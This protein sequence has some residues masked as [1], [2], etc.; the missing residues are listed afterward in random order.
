[1][2]IEG[3]FVQARQDII[4]SWEL[5]RENWRAFVSTEIFSIIAFICI[6]VGLE[7]ILIAIEK[8]FVLDSVP[9]IKISMTFISVFIG[10]LVL[11]I[12]LACQYGLAYDIISSGDMFAEFKGAF[13]YFKRYWWRYALLTFLTQWLQGVFQPPIL[14]LRLFGISLDKFQTGI[15]SPIIGLLI[16]SL[17][18]Y[19]F[20]FVLF[21]NTLPSITFQKSL[22][23]SFIENIKIIRRIPQR[24]VM[25][26][27][28]VFFIFIVPEYLINI[29]TII[30]FNSIVNTYWKFVP[31]ILLILTYIFDLFIGTPMI[32]L[33]ATRIYNSIELE[34]EKEKEFL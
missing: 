16:V 4:I 15:L 18:F 28:F 31:A 23:Q 1:M 14:I 20:W 33:I 2:S 34:N 27:E 17:F 10:I 24:I 5:L 7:S 19:F 29:I 6:F 22:V 26:W 13:T 11:Y 9:Y 3:D 30:I 8:I 25:K 21:I 32:A 12:F